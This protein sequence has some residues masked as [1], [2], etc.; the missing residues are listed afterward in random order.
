[1]VV[2]KSVD[3]ETV[4]VALEGLTM[5]TVAIL[6]TLRVRFAKAIT[7]GSA[8]GDVLHQ[9]FS[10]FTSQV[11]EYALPSEFE[12]WIPV[13]YSSYYAFSSSPAAIKVTN[14]SSSYTSDYA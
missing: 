7:L 9:M 11:L 1:M 8:I 5:A 4:S 3:P 6:A 12:K 10:P 2:S 14:R 13:S